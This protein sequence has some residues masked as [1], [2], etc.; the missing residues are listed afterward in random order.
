MSFPREPSKIE[1]HPK[2]GVVFLSE[3]F[4]KPNAKGCA[5]GCEEIGWKAFP[6]GGYKLSVDKGVQ[7]VRIHQTARDKG[8]V[9]VARHFVVQPGEVYQLTAR[10]RI[11]TKTGTFK[12]RV[13]MAARE[14][15]GPQ[16]K[17]F[18]AEPQ[19]ETSDAPVERIVRATIPVGASQ[20]TVRVKF[21]TSE[22]GESGQGEIYAMKLER[23]K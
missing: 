12:A 2:V 22:A 1:A 11:K 19:E 5:Q 10:V 3:K 14:A 8:D 20:L 16:I 7:S 15:E 21:H 17:E 9:G 23:I 13:N 18:N 6:R 4:D